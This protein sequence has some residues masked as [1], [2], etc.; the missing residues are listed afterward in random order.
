MAE[1]SS[2]NPLSPEIT[3]KEEPVT[4]KKL[5]SLNPFLPASEVEFSF[6]E[7]SL[8]A[9]NEVSL[10]YPSHSN[11]EYFESVLDF[12][13]KCCL[14]EAF[15]RALIQY[16]EYLGNIGINTFRNA[17]RAHFPPHS[18]IYVS[19]P[20]ITILRPWFRII[21][22]SREIGAKGTLKKSF[23][24]PRVKVDYAKLIWEDIIHK[25]NKKIREKVVPYPRFI[26]FLLEYMMLEYDNEELTINP[27]QA[28]CNLDVPVHFE[29]PNLPH[30]TKEVPQAKIIE[31]KVDSEENNLQNTLLTSLKSE[32]NNLHS[33]SA[34]R[35]DASANSIAEAG[36]TNPSVLVDQ[37][38]SAR[39]GLKTA[40]TNS[41]TN[42]EFGADAISK[43]IKLEDLSDLWKDTRSA[44]F[45]PDSP[46]DKPI[47]VSDESEKEEEVDKD[48]D[49]Y[50]TSHD[51]PEDTL[52]PHPSS[53]KSAQIQELMAQVQLLQFQKDELEQQKAKFKAEVAL[54]KARSSYPDINQLTDLLVT[55]LNPKFY[56]LLA[57]HNFAN[58]LPNT[59]KELPSKFTE[60]SRE[61]KKL[62]TLDSLPSL[63]NKV[64]DTL[65]R[66][67]TMVKN[68]SGATNK[69]VPSTGQVTA[70]PAKGEKNTN[71]A[72]MDVEPN[73]HD[74]LVDLLV[75]ACPD[76]KEKGWKTIYG[77]IKTIMEY[78]DQTEKELKIDFNKP[79]KEQDP[80]KELNDLAN[81]KR[82][83]TGDSTDHSRSTKKHKSSVSMKKSFIDQQ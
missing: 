83:R 69:D 65:N 21:G 19:S 64:T 80:L 58:C 82:K 23:L 24:L 28:I 74:E 14:E 45:T 17:L 48:K 81:K 29:A 35:H 54:L 68:A 52:I 2:H 15:T 10:L 22:Y 47:I 11:S 73:L 70:S 44:F 50:A 77:L 30:K 5:E 53:P 55:S 49:T 18:S 20:S 1:S 46:Q 57:L 75:Q 41:G 67:A 6:D 3:Y 78:L 31:L 40:H 56:K 71:P 38:K 76:R 42:E 66:F 8:T 79:L 33:E 27:T 62:K 60:L 4:L 37:T 59:L 36:R 25:L 63:L 16:K 39:D 13:F 26:S 12:I 32:A 7:I 43:K 34:S 72:T 51:V 61:I 9:N